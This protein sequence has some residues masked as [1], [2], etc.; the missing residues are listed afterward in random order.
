MYVSMPILKTLYHVMPDRVLAEGA[1]AVWTV[2]IQ[3][4]ISH[5]PVR[6][7]ND[8]GGMGARRP[9]EGPSATCYPTGVGVST[10]SPTQ[11]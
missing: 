8:S 11:K 9:K 4:A 3:G 2:Q 5:L 10:R 1:G 7:F 6:M